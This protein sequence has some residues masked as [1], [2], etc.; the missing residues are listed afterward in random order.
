MLHTTHIHPVLGEWWVLGGGGWWVLGGGTHLLAP[1]LMSNVTTL[2][3]I[4]ELE[5]LCLAG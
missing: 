2:A 4:R 3:H 5:G 1:F